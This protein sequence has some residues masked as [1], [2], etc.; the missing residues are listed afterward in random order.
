M[1]SIFGQHISKRPIDLDASLVK[2][3]HDIKENLIRT[4]T[5]EEI[6]PC[7]DRPY[8]EVSLNDP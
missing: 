3:F 4:K 5:Y 2:Y 1:F 8:K 6:M 7:M